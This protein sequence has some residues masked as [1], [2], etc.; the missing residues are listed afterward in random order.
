MNSKSQDLGNK[1]NEFEDIFDLIAKKENNI[2]EKTSSNLD[3]VNTET[4]KASSEFDDKISDNKSQDSTDLLVKN[5]KLT[6]KNAD[7]VAETIELT[8]NVDLTEEN[9]TEKNNV[10]GEELFEAIEDSVTEE[11][12]FE[13]EAKLSK[14]AQIKDFSLFLLKY[15]STSLWIFLLLMVVVNFSAYYQIAQ[16]YFNAWGQNIVSENL[17]SSVLEAKAEEKLEEKKEVKIAMASE[18]TKQELEKNSKM[19]RNEV[20]HS[21]DKLLVETRDEKID[22]SLDI[23]PYEN[24]VV[25]PKM[26]K[27]IPLLDVNKKSAKDIKELEKIFMKDLENWIIRY[28]WSALPWEKWN[29]FIFWHSSNFPWAK[30]DYNDVFANLDALKF[31][32]EIIVYYWQKKYVYE[33]MTKKVISPGNVKIL[34]R[35]MGRNEVTLM[36]CFPVWTTLNRLI[37][38]WKLKEEENSIISVNNTEANITKNN[39]IKK[40]EVVKW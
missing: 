36:T 39:K 16:G 17:K 12:I 31:R 2:S 24:R 11:N 19:S 22:L 3:W 8:K 18:E 37:V 38:I 9:I 14:F 40:E 1:A 25:I 32:D 34:K 28:P 21:M 15:L 7:L 4:I 33:V 26:W 13:E 30:G 10:S 29:T 6:E 5:A 20:F 27:N 23:T 35:N